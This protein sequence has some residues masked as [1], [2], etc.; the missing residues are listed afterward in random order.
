[1]KFLLITKNITKNG[2]TELVQIFAAFFLVKQ[3]NKNIYTKLAMAS[4]R[5]F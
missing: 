1:M 5:S 4:L 3:A 2:V